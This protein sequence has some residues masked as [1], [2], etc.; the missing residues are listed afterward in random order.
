M[1]N[2]TA[3]RICIISMTKQVAYNQPIHSVC[4]ST[5]VFV[6]FVRSEIKISIETFQASWIIPMLDFKFFDSHNNESTT[7]L[8][9]LKCVTQMRWVVRLLGRENTLFC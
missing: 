8:V 5:I 9:Q 7:E 4:H 2:E 3:R 6:L 1:D